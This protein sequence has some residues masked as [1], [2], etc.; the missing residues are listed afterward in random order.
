MVMSDK[1]TLKT[2]SIKVRSTTSSAIVRLAY[3]L[4]HL[5]RVIAMLVVTASMAGTITVELLTIASED[6]TSAL[7]LGFW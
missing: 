3:N 6:E 7:L 1:F 2:K 5:K 4:E